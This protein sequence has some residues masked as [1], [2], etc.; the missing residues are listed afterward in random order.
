MAPPRKHTP[1]FQ[2]QKRTRT[3]CGF[4]QA[5]RD[6]PN[7][8]QTVSVA[9]SLFAIKDIFYRLLSH[10]GCKSLLRSI[11]AQDTVWL[12]DNTAYR[13]MKTGG[14]EAEYVAALFSQHSS[15][16]IIEA[17]GAVADKLE[18]EKRDPEYKA[19]EERVWPFLQDVKPGA[20]VQIIHKGEKAMKLGPSGKNGIVCSIKTLPSGRGGRVVPTLARV[21]Q[22]ANGLLEMRTFYADTEGWGVISDIDDTI[23]ITQTSDPVGILRTTFVETPRPTRGMPELYGHIHSLIG[24]ASSW[25]YLSASPYNLYP[26]LRDFRDSYYPQGTIFLRDSSWMS[27]SGLL[28]MLTIDTKE[29]KIDRMEKI[30]SWLPKRKMI[31]VGDSTQ[32]DPEAY[33]EIYRRHPD[34]VK[35]I[36]IR[37]VEDIAAIGIMAKNKPER[38]ENA[39]KGVPRDVWHVFTEPQT[40]RELVHGVVSKHS[41]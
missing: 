23:K 21:P 30:H 28:T 8:S 29:Y 12:F 25:F 15:C 39:F 33:G 16:S 36:L 7:F 20:Q 27:I 13:N 40:C 26:F 24:D 17:V 5:E 18:L 11:T 31:C 3:E 2:M 14:W 4:D 6:L 41:S 9:T 38:F 19:L 34:W 37:K 32:T 22:G 10:L 35:I 1:S